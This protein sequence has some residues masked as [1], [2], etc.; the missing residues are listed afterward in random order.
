MAWKFNPFLGT[1]TKL[2]QTKSKTELNADYVKKPSDTMG[3]TLTISHTYTPSPASGDSEPAIVANRH[4]IIKAG[5]KLIFD[6]S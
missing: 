1:K 5:H 3:G 6:G 4:I 2:D